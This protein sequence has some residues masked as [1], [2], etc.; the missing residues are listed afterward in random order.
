MKQTSLYTLFVVLFTGLLISSCKPSRVWTTKKK[1]KQE[2]SEPVVYN[3]RPVA[4][5]APPPPPRYYNAT[6]LLISPTPGF[7]MKQDR[8][9]RFFHRTPQGLLYWKGYDNRFY[10]DSYYVQNVRYSSWEYDEWN[11]YRRAS[12]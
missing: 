8:S 5:P 2:K 12:R 3:R 4:E 9:G 7:V 10:L 11:R 6:P 1:E